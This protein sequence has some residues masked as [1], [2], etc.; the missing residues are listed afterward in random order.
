MIIVVYLLQALIPISSWLA[1]ACVAG[2]GLIVY[3]IGYLSFGASAVE[4]QTWNGLAFS[5]WHFARV[6]LKQS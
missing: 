2:I 6:H 4:R 1:L 3:V 5:A